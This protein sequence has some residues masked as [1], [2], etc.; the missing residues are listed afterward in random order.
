MIF[1]TEMSSEFERDQ[2]TKKL[3]I[4]NNSKFHHDSLVQ[5][6]TKTG[7]GN[8]FFKVNKQSKEEEKEEI[9]RK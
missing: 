5:S 8:D 3:V 1:Q 4:P 9:L 6:T 7:V 2:I